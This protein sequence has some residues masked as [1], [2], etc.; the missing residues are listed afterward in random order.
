MISVQS[1]IGIPV[2]L[3]TFTVKAT[4]LNSEIIRRPSVSDQFHHKA[5]AAVE[6]GYS[7]PL[8]FPLFP[9]R[10]LHLVPL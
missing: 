9:R 8:H 6:D 1:H 7:R 10:A 5:T 4:G 2:T 3:P